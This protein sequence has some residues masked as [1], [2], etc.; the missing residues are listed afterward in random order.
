M[1]SLPLLLSFVTKTSSTPLRLVWKAPGV[2]GKSGE[3]VVPVTY[4]LPAQST[5][6]LAT[7][8]WLV[9][10]TAQDMWSRPRHCR[11]C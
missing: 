8:Y 6:M 3:S 2:V 5:V 1:R 7:K 10:L 4:A 9:R 11:Y